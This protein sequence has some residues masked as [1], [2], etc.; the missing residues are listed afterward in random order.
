MSD[1]FRSLG[2][3]FDCMEGDDTHCIF[4]KVEKGILDQK[5]IFRTHVQTSIPH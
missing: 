5:Y 2:F 3:N 4:A 1:E